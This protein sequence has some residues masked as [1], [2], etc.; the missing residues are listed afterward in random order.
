M[1]STTISIRVR[2][3]E[4]DQMGVV[5]HGNYATYCEVARVEFF[6]ELDMPYKELETSGIMLPV[7]ELN[8]KFI[9]PAYYDEVLKIQTTLMEIPSGVRLKFQYAIYNE[10]NE[11]LTTGFSALAFIDMKTRKPVRCP[12]YMIENLKRISS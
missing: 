1:I 3:G 5:Y 7:T 11:L 9:Q 2:Y 12:D 4:T 8:L 10:S 6:R